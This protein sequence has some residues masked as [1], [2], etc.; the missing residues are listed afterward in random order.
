MTNTARTATAPATSAT[1]AEMT[2]GARS[3][4]DNAPTSLIGLVVVDGQIKEV[5]RAHIGTT[6]TGNTVHAYA[7]IGPWNGI[8]STSGGGYH[9]PSAALS[10]ALGNAGFSFDH[11]FMSVGRSAMIDGFR[12]ACQSWADKWPEMGWGEPGPVYVVEA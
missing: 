1:I 2:K 10:L 7:S 9:K 12:A 4:L 3:M 8:A 6:P 5:G 11:S